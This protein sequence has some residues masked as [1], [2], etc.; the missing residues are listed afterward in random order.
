MTVADLFRALSQADVEMHHEIR[1]ELEGDD[2]T[3][4]EIEVVDAR[5]SEG[6]DYFCL[7]VRNT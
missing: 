4:Q 5:E 3:P 6:V 1:I 7:V 2:N